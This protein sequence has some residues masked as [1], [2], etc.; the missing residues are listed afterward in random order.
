MDNQLF[1]IEQ[2]EISVQP[3]NRLRQWALPGG[4]LAISEAKSGASIDIAGLQAPSFEG[5]SA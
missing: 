5:T 2:G 1:N 3:Y 4:P